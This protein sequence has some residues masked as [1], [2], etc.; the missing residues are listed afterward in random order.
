[1]FKILI[2]LNLIVVIVWDIFR[3]PDEMAGVFMGIITK[4]KIKSAKLVKP[5]GCSLCM[6]FW[7]SLILTYV[8]CERSIEGFLVA[9]LIS[10]LNA[11]MTKYTYQLILLTEK[12]AD[13]IIYYINERIK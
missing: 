4:G 11:Y 5:F 2:L 8:F 10:L 1:M 13:K 6:T 9:T 7:L 3:A 12:L